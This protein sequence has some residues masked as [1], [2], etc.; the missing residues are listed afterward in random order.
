[1]K[2]T[3][4]QK[5]LVVLLSLSLAAPAF[6]AIDVPPFK[7]SG[8]LRQYSSFNLEDIPETAEDDKWDMSMNRWTAFLDAT[9]STG[10][11]RWTGRFR[12]TVEGLTD[13][14]ERLED[15]ANFLRSVDATPGRHSDFTDEY[16]EVD[17]REL[18]FDTDIGDN[19]FFRFGR[20]QVV[21]GETDFFHATDVIHGYDFRWRNFYVPE[22]EDVRK[23]LIILN[24]VFQVPALNGS[25][26]AILRPGWDKDEWVGNSIPTFG[27]RWSAN[28][29]KGFPL[30]S[31]E[32][33]GPA[34]FIP[35]GT[36]G[37]PGPIQGAIFNYHSEHGDTDDAHYGLRW[38]GLLGRNDDID[39]SLMYY[40]GQ[41]GFQQDPVLYLNPQT[42]GLEFIFPETDTFGATLSSYIPMLN[43]TYR[44][45]VA[46]T[47]DRPF[48]SSATTPLP[49]QVVEEDAWNFL[50]GFDANPRLQNILGT[51]SQSLFTVQVFDWYLP[52]VEKTDLIGNFT[53]SG[54][55]RE[56][57][58]LATSIFTL[59][60]MHDTLIG[61]LVVI[62]D[63][64]QGGG[65]VIPSIEYQWGPHWRF[66]LE[67]DLTW[68][69]QSITNPTAPDGNIVGYFENNNQLLL[70]TTFQ[71]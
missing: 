38:T 68:G 10:P 21:W 9:T 56:H 15:T 53:G 11:L 70:R 8:Y 67:A 41:G 39:Y 30:A 66:K 50:L 17:V 2:P 14:E 47:P 44:A 7:I 59:P 42:F 28:L 48:T 18:F 22:N 43:I 51:S 20:Q 5:S 49:L 71:F 57:N 60:Y 3:V 55:Y 36:I 26:Q 27:G 16:N 25:L 69:G 37:N 29:S 33:D 1:M 40:H 64:T 13:Y 31:N 62:A 58:V 61:T 4:K 34:L 19:F 35:P 52:D 12:A 6:A 32:V 45:E 23:P 65:W 54:V 24:G 63:L 46:Y